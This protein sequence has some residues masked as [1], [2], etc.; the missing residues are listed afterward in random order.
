M[1]VAQAHTEEAIRNRCYKAIFDLV[2]Q[3]GLAIEVMHSSTDWL[4]H[5]ALY[6]W[7]LTTDPSKLLYLQSPFILPYLIDKSRTSLEHADL[8]WQRYA[9]QEN[10]LEAA[11]VLQDLANSDFPITFYQRLEYIS[12]ARSYCSS[13]SD[14]SKA[15][16]IAGL[17]QACEDLLEVSA[18]Q[19][20]IIS[21]IKDD[22]RI[23]DGRK[24]DLVEMLNGK[25]LSLSDLFNNFADPLGYK[26]ICL[27]IF[28]LANF[29]DQ[30]VIEKYKT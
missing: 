23:P 21:A 13:R 18:V 20:D 6:D 15:D 19:E 11:M 10:W 12:R 3:D 29:Q 17:R 7:Y 9:K 4:F 8:L 22:T 24:N 26:K 14:D 28:S 2:P 5:R 16:I 27:N 1:A 30:Q 25:I